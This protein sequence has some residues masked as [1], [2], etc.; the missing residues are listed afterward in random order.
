MLPQIRGGNELIDS[1]KLLEHGGIK[2]GFK[3][4]DLGC[5]TA[6]HFVLPAAH[7]VG[8]QGVVY[9]VD[10]LKPVLQSIENKARFEGLTNI[11]TIWADIERKGG[12]NI[13]DGSVDVA[14]LTN[15]LFQI[16]D[17]VIVLSETARILKAGGLLIVAEWKAAGAPFGP[18]AM[19]R[20]EPAIIKNQAQEAGFE[21]IKEFEAGPRHFGLVFRKK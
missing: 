8:N 5:G 20:I 17:K 7:L 9:A 1:Q 21:L 19:T 11:K 2:A 4:A 15:T 10:I 3:V 18:P 14:L 16:K 12:M 13:T 6:G